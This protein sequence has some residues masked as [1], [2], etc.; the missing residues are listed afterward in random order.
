ME[1]FLETRTWMKDRPELGDALFHGDLAILRRCPRDEKRRSYQSERINCLLRT[2]IDWFGYETVSTLD[3][4]YCVLFLLIYRI[5][6]HGMHMVLYNQELMESLDPETMVSTIDVSFKDPGMTP[7]HTYNRFNGDTLYHFVDSGTRDVQHDTG[8]LDRIG[9]DRRINEYPCIGYIPEEGT[10]VGDLVRSAG[11]FP[12]MI[13]VHDYRRCMDASASV[14][15]DEDN[16]SSKWRSGFPKT[17]EAILSAELCAERTSGGFTMIPMVVDGS[18]YADRPVRLYR[19]C[20]NTT[21]DAL[22]YNGIGDVD[23]DYDQICLA[24]MIDN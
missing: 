3:D 2:D 4:K 9:R 13:T 12:T 15:P 7:M 17:L 1:E 22:C 10:T 5:L 11:N 6:G 21:Q 23:M 19:I 24:L 18:R 14:P 20:C 16:A 8:L